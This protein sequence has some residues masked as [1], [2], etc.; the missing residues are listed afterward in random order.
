M[1]KLTNPWINLP[2]NA[3]FVLPADIDGIAKLNKTNN[4]NYKIQTDSIP[5]PFIGPILSAKI[6]L[7]ALNPGHSSDDFQWQN[8]LEFKNK[9]LE[10]QKNGTTP[11]YLLD[12]ALK[13]SPA[14]R[15]WNQKLKNLIIKVG[16]EKVQND[17]AVAQWLPY[18]S[19]KF[20]SPANF[21]LLPSQNFTFQL[22]NH[23]IKKK[24]QVVV[25]RSYKIWKKNIK[26]PNNTIHL[27]N[28]LNPSVTEN[29]MS[30]EDFKK[31]INILV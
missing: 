26:L 7:L 5:E 2:S 27:K 21:K 15:Y 22:V 9:M 24:G 17:I 25:M 12:P 4:S 28:P 30:K 19:I 16:L 10:N 20:Q 8:K 31:L 11:F 3:P 13:D 14:G 23:F 18:H 6:L 29:N 1:S